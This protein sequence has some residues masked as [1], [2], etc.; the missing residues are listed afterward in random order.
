MNWR[1]GLQSGWKVSWSPGWWS[2]AQNQL[3]AGYWEYSSGSKHPPMFLTNSLADETNSWANFK[4]SAQLKAVTSPTCLCPCLLGGPW[5]HTPGQGRLEDPL[6]QMLWSAFVFCPFSGT[7]PRAGDPGWHR[8]CFTS[9]LVASLGLSKDPFSQ[10]FFLCLGSSGYCPW[11]TACPAYGSPS[12]EARPRT[13]TRTKGTVRK[14]IQEATLATIYT[15][16][17]LP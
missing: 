17:H 2:A 9:F 12:P 10:L 13:L 4:I 3:T 15:E 16:T 8:V 5:P 7:I 1:H 6:E 11:A 14:Q